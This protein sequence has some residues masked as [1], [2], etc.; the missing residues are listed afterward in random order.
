MLGDSDS[1]EEFKGLEAYYPVSPEK[2]IVQARLNKVGGVLVLDV[3]HL[4]IH[5]RDERC[6]QWAQQK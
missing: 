3:E 5:L 4:L 2:W 6:E 1:P